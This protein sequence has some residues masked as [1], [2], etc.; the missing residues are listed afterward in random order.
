M[1]GD[2]LG[3]HSEGHAKGGGM[4]EVEAKRVDDNPISRED[5]VTVSLFHS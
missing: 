3:A 2:G 1:Q 4:E 5:S